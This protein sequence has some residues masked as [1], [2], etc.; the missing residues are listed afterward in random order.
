M[1]GIVNVLN[2]IWL[3][4]KRI[5]CTHRSDCDIR[6]EVVQLVEQERNS[7]S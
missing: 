4:N 3:E 2:V 6:A 7:V 1:D 5:E